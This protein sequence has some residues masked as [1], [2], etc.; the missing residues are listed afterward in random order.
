MKFVIFNLVVGTA[1]GYLLLWDGPRLHPDPFGAWTGDASAVHLPAVE[2]G[3]VPADGAPSGRRNAGSVAPD[4]LLT[5]ASDAAAASAQSL[6]D[7]AA[8]RPVGGAVDQATGRAVDQ[9]VDRVVDSRPAR[10]LEPGGGR[11]DTSAERAPAPLPTASE[12]APTGRSTD[13][14]LARRLHELARD[15]EGRFL[16][17]IR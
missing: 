11:G 14:D 12:A 4:A 16:T 5:P 3:A 9:V 10:L 15:M 6:A 2:A 13:P 7:A 1:L 17:G 8:G